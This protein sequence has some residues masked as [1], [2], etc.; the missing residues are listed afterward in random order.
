MRTAGSRPS[1]GARRLRVRR[2]LTR[3]RWLQSRRRSPPTAE[4]AQAVRRRRRAEA[5]EALDRRGPRGLGQVHLHHRRH[6]DPRGAGQRD[7]SIAAGR[8]VRQAGDALRRAEAAADVGA[9]AQAPEALA[10]AGRAGGSGRGGGADAHRGRDGG[11]LR[12]GQVL[13]AGGRTS[14]STSRTSR[15]SWRPS[16]DPKELLDVWTG[17]HTIAPPIK[18]DFARY[19][20][21]ANK[22]AR[23]LGFT[24][25]GA[26]WRSKYDMPPDDFA[27]EVDR[28]WEQVKPLYDSL[29]SYVRWKLREKYG[30][31]VPA[32]GPDPGA[33]ARQHVGADVGQHLSARGADGRRPGLRPDR[34]S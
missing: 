24:D 2:A 15:R 32:D 23:E 34:R 16:R 22:G 12:Q 13:P 9:Q 7:R 26:M 4:E 25:T 10:D 28:L 18:K 31:A 1:A 29:H 27:A 8:R 6:R 21:L 19:V 30:D 17:W 3:R 5:A 14:A 33:P 11:H 20:E